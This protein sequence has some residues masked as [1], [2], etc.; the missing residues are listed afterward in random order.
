MVDDVVAARS[1]YPDRVRSL[2]GEA[3]PRLPPDPADLGSSI[4]VPSAVVALTSSGAA[5]AGRGST[6]TISG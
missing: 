4:A 2:V 1:G 3:P 6:C 5:E